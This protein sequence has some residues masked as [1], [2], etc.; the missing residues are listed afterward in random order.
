MGKDRRGWIYQGQLGYA[1]KEY[2]EAHPPAA[3]A[4][5]EAKVFEKAM[6]QTLWG[7]YNAT[8]LVEWCLHGE[9]NSL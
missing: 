1:V 4:D 2:D 8:T 9:T 3:C 6:N 5:D 7:L